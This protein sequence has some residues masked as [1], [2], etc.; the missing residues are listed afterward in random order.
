MTHDNIQCCQGDVY[1]FRVDA[2]PEAEKA[3]PVD[4]NLRSTFVYWLRSPR[5]PSPVW[6]VRSTVTPKQRYRPVCSLPGPLRRVSP[7]AE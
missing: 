5:H 3:K 6:A 2:L 7:D 1:L 4:E